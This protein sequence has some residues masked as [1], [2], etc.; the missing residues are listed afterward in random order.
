M[1][2]DVDIYK[3]FDQSKTNKIGYLVISITYSLLV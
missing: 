2:A 3:S 1:G